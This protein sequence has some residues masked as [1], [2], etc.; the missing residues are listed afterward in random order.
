MR[1]KRIFILLGHP[2]DG[3]EPLSRQLA[4]AY[5]ASAEASGHEVRRLDISAL[6][7]DPILHKGYRA[8]QELEPDLKLVQ[9][10]L[11]WC[12]HFALFYPNWWGGM[13]G[14][15]KGMWDR[16]FL[17]RF[18]FRMWK[19]RFGWDAL[20]KG[21]TARV[22]ITCGNP[23]ILDHLAFGDFTAGI[24]RSLL[25]FAGFRTWVTTVGRS[26]HLSERTTDAWKQRMAYLGQRGA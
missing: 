13:P 5:E 19:N 16:M 7:F 17:P 14:E 26:E 12:E 6:T 8:I 10:N 11:S 9:E 2:D 18:A 1:T 24:K 21:R 20:L 15:L 3:A 25:Q 4:D 22:V 23:V